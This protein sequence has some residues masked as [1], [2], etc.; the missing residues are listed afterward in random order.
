VR[1]EADTLQSSSRCAGGRFLDAR[2]PQ[3]RRPRS[4][5]YLTSG[6]EQEPSMR[7]RL[8]RSRQPCRKSPRND[9]RRDGP[10]RGSMCSGGEDP[11]G[12][13]LCPVESIIAELEEAERSQ[14]LAYAD[15]KRLSGLPWAMLPTLVPENLA[16]SADGLRH[17]IDAILHEVE[18][19]FVDPGT[20]YPEVAAEAGHLATQL[21]ACVQ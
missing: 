16:L 11:E 4:D 19:G 18:E 13:V 2:E 9:I 3:L 7:R 8:P 1:P 6:Q 20:S 14:R 10:R 5:V 12:R 15:A 17:E 21:R